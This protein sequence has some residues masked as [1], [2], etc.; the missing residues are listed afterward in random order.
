M[1]NSRTQIELCVFSSPGKK[2]FACA[3]LTLQYCQVQLWECMWKCP[4]K[5]NVLH[6]FISSISIIAIIIITNRTL[7][8]P[9][10]VLRL[11]WKLNPI[12]FTWIEIKMKLFLWE[13][14]GLRDLLP[15]SQHSCQLTFRTRCK[16]HLFPQTFTPWGLIWEEI[17]QTWCEDV[18]MNVNVYV[19]LFF[20]LYTCSKC[21]T[22]ID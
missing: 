13:G 14:P 10:W 6:T 20:F 12:R 9:S 1:R 16:V 4:E 18:S 2:H 19:V 11:Q 7:W 21:L 3:F 15:N 17:S 22:K 5:Y 8:R